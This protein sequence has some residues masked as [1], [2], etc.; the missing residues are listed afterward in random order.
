MW[1]VLAALVTG[2]FGLIGILVNRSA[3]GVTRKN[4]EE[5]EVNKATLDRIEAVVG[6]TAKAVTEHLT[7]HLNQS[8]STTTVVVHPP[9]EEAAA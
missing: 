5:H 6:S 3:K 2:G 1:V 8:P 9:K 4:T 7:W